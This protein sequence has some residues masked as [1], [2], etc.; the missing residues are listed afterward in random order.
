M[1]L[2][3]TFEAMRA[4]ELE[5]TATEQAEPNTEVDAQKEI[6]SKYAEWA[7]ETLKKEYGEGNYDENDVT[8]LAEAKIE[9]DAAEEENR[10]K[11]A[12]YYEAGQIMYAGFK[13]AAEADS[14]K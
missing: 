6:L 4:E 13:A 12:E 1:S 14:N 2:L 9:A 5:K 8:K 3:D 10:E 7:D 11:V